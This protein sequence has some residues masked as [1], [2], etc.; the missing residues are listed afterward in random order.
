MIVVSGMYTVVGIVCTF[1]VYIAIA[2]FI[3]LLCIHVDYIILS[4]LLV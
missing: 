3:I 1:I 2:S 4:Q